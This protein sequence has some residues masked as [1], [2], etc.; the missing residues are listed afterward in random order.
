MSALPVAYLARHGA[1]AWTV[2]RLVTGREKAEM[3]VG[4]R[5]RERHYSDLKGS[6][7]LTKES[8]SRSSLPGGGR[9]GVAHERDETA[10]R[11]PRSV[12]RPAAL[13]SRT[14]TG[15]SRA[16]GRLFHLCR[17]TQRP[18]AIGLTGKN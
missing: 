3:R 2:S 17:E 4:V 12:A 5:A 1:T 7:M 9:P 15:P 11:V 18:R 10:A 14:G 16:N 6:S 13:A 8:R